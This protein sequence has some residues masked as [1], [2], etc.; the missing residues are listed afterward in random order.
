MS[1]DVSL[2]IVENDSE[3]EVYE[4]NITHNLGLMA[5]KAGIYE[6][7]WKPESLNKVF[8]K[9]LI[10]TLEAGLSNLKARPLYFIQFNASNGWGVY[11]HFVP[12]IS[13]YLDACRKYPDSI[14]KVSR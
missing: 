3:I 13:R 1:L 9:D 7:L 14:I 8:A 4:A 12:F 5:S 6:A 10:E 2:Y 11:E